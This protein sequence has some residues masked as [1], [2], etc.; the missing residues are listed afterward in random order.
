[1]CRFYRSCRR[2]RIITTTIIITTTTIIIG[3]CDK[4]GRGRGENRVDKGKRNKSLFASFSSEKK[5]KLPFFGQ[6]GKDFFISTDNGSVT[7]AP[8]GN[9]GRFREISSTAGRVRA[10]CPAGRP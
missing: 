1:L 7:A 4:S 10:M 8:K 2:P 3:R 6:E 5:K 9:G